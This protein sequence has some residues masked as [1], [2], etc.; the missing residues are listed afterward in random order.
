V[1]VQVS[2]VARALP[3]TS[4]TPALIVALYWVLVASATVGVKVATKVAALYV[5]LPAT[6]APPG[7]LSVKVDVLM[8]AAFIA[9]LK[10]VLTMA[11]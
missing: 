8:V 3:T 4:V 7:P 2:S 10:V 5:T 11:L 1:K 9:L 6:L